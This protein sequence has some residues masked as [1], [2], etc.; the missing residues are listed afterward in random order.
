M[1]LKEVLTAI[2]TTAKRNDL[3]RPYLVGGFPRDVYMKT[4]ENIADLDIT[5]GNED[6]KTL[7]NRLVENL[8]GTVLKTFDDGH[9]RIDYNKFKI[10]FSNN[11]KIP[12]I[13]NILIGSGIK[14][15]TPMQEELYSRDFTINTLLMPMNLSSVIDATGLAME[16]IRAN[17]IDTCLSPRI[18]LGYDPKRIIRIV[19]L[20]AKL[21]FTPSKRVIEWVRKNNNIVN[22]VSEG[23]VKSRI[24][25]SLKIN[26]ELTNKM[27]KILNLNK[28]IPYIRGLTI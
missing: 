1:P 2:D 21:N 6:T 22:K 7:A 17:R 15:P 27:I 24:G 26:P 28:T 12:N 18:T 3:S 8:P 25:K 19:Y 4:I 13:K 10:D 11:F 5:C 20:S 9:S 16:D 14:N 23:Y